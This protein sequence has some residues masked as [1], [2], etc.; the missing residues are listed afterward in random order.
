VPTR[1]SATAP[2]V[3]GVLG[4]AAGYGSYATHLLNGRGALLLALAVAVLPVATVRRAAGLLLVCGATMAYSAGYQRGP[5]GA[6][7]SAG[8]VTWTPAART[9]STAP[10]TITVAA[11]AAGDGGYQ[12][13]DVVLDHLSRGVVYFG[14]GD[15]AGGISYHRAFRSPDSRLALTLLVMPRRAGG[16]LASVLDDQT[17]RSARTRFHLDA[18]AGG[19][20]LKR[21]A[22]FADPT[23]DVPLVRGRLCEPA[24]ASVLVHFGGLPATATVRLNYR[25]DS[26]TT[27][28]NPDSS[29]AG[30]EGY[31][32]RS[33]QCTGT[34]LDGFNVQVLDNHGDVVLSRTFSVPN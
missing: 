12:E 20:A 16:Y 5:V 28:I 9:A 29:G 25:G 21:L 32:F 27:G 10:V 3:L 15:V 4:A 11:H 22:G 24:G 34:L 23:L 18:S 1:A 14:I 17:G 13:V 8:A 26:V 2:L 33:Q 6:P 19:P 31:V 7:V 30:V